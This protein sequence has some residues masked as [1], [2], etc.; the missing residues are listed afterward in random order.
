MGQRRIGVAL[1]D[2]EGILA[3]PLTVIHRTEEAADMDQ[4][5]SLVRQH[6]VGRIVVGLPR[7]LDGSLGGEARGVQ[8]FVERLSQQAPV[9]V[10]VWDERLS[11]VA[12]R[13][14]LAEA[15]VKKKKIK[16]R[17]DAAAAALILQ[18]YLDRMRSPKP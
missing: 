13:R 16:E 18:G 10:E 15:G 7:S 14:L 1:S 11:T 9:P 2:S 4:I 3:S 12:A 6:E 5:I 8:A 17:Q